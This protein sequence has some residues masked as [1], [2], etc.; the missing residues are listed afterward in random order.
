LEYHAK[1]AKMAETASDVLQSN[2]AGQNDDKTGEDFLNQPSRKPAISHFQANRLASS[3]NAA[4]PS[5]SKSLG[6]NV[7]PASTAQTFQRAIRMGKL[8][9]DNHLVGGD[10]GES[11][12]DEEVDAAMQEI[13]ELLKKGEVYNLGPDGNYVHIVPPKPAEASPPAIPPLVPSPDGPPPSSR[14]PSTSKFKLARSGRTPTA[15]APSPDVS[16]SSTPI[17]NVGRSSPKEPTLSSPEPTVLSSTVVEKPPSSSSTAFNSMIIDSP[18][19][20]QSRRPQQ[21]P[22]VVRAADKPAKVSRFLAER[23]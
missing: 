20:P 3:Y 5:S 10:A 21:P 9:S 19:F 22:T 12:S 13:T 16:G 15:A 7:V 1:R 4:T 18:S 17:S 23:M 6:A 11:G 2:F 14:K 8:D